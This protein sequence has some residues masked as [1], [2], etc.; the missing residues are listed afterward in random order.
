[1]LARVG[2]GG[3][4]AGRP[5]SRL[6][7]EAV[8]LGPRLPRGYQVNLLPRSRDEGS[9]RFAAGRRAGGEEGEEGGGGEKEGRKEGERGN[10]RGVKPLQSKEARNCARLSSL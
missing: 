5:A 10:D 8:K 6:G 7:L 1:M 4:G 2:G 3:E 9:T